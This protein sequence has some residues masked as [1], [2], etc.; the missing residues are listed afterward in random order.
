[1]RDAVMR[2][3]LASVLCAAALISPIYAQDVDNSRAVKILG[4]DPANPPT[5]TP[6]SVPSTPRLVPNAPSLSPGMT[7]QPLKAENPAGISVDILPGT[8]VTAGEKITFRVATKK[9]GYLVL[10][11][12]DAAG[13]LKQIYPNPASLMAPGGANQISNR[14]TSARP[15]TVPDPN[16]P[17]SGFELVASPPAGVAMVV[18]ILSDRP[19]QM[20]DLPDVPATLTGRTDALSYLTEFA[21]NLRIARAGGGGTFEQPQWS[22]DAKFYV[23]K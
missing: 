11:D 6:P 10:V 23:V 21:R 1:M 18:A 22:F 5:L 12:V 16:N 20:L 15:I 13:K 8:E 9:T 14:I 19:V 7:D 3:L 17:Y 4:S 2:C